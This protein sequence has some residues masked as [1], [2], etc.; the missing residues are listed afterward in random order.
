MME[1]KEM[2][3]S[4]MVTTYNKAAKAKGSKPVKKFADRET[5]MKRTKAMLGTNKPTTKVTT[6]GKSR[7]REDYPWPKSEA[8][9]KAR[10]DSLRGRFIA[11]LQKGTTEAQLLGAAKKYYEEEGKSFPEGFSVKEK[12]AIINRYSGVGI[13]E[14]GGKL[15][16]I[17]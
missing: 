16:A 10:E 3:M 5:A 12:L 17:K 14:V 15:V 8:Q 1:L 9:Y 6:R 4:E 7:I 2:T 11:K 13:K